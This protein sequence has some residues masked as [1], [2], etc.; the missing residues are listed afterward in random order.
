MA[1]IDFF[2]IGENTTIK[3]VNMNGITVH[4]EDYEALQ[5]VTLTAKPFAQ[6]WYE[7]IGKEKNTVGE[8][9]DGKH[10]YFFKV[11][12][13]VEALKKE[14]KDASRWEKLNPEMEACLISTACE[15]Q[16]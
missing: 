10:F 3:V 5:G 13:A 16:N 14:G 6:F 11:I 4:K 15:V 12:D 9:L 1:G 2:P 7:Y 8:A